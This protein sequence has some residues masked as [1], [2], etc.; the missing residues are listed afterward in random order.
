MCIKQQI[1]IEVVITKINL[2]VHNVLFFDSCTFLYYF[3]R[4][5]LFLITTQLYLGINFYIYIYIHKY[6]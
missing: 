5:I 1:P 4:R 6:K 3:F 2:A